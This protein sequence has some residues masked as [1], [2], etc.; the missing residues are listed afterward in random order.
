MNLQWFPGHMAKTRRMITENMKLV[1]AVVELLDAR[2]PLSSRNPEIDRIVGSK[3]RVLVLNKA[4]MADHNATEV[5][6]NWFNEKGYA[7]I[8]VDSQS[9]RGFSALEPAIRR[10]MKEKLERERARGIQRSSIRLMV[11][12]IPNV[13]KSSFINRLAGRGAARTGDRPGITTAKQWIRIA[14]KYELLDT[15]GILWPKFEDP[16]VAKRIAFTG[17]IRDEIMDLEELSCEL[18]GFLSAHYADM[19]KARYKLEDGQLKE[20]SYDLL[21]QIGKKRGCIVSGGNIDTLR[22]A[23]LVL[24]D[25]RSVRIGTIT[26]EMPE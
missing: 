2:L 24:D 16:E 7:V 11:V 14:G 22:A 15:P 1:D 19:L 18:L 8:A 5:W 12:G 26:L 4:D 17:G 6:K 13:G 10:V 3:P 25:F 9:G 20:S 23:S 21:M